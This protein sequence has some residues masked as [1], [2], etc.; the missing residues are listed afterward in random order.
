M[1]RDRVEGLPSPTIHL[2]DEIRLHLGKD[3]GYFKYPSI[4]RLHISKDEILEK[5]G[6]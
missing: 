3:H 1:R 2:I 4:S 5:R 6:K